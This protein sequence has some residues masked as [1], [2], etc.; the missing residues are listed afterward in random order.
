MQQFR[1]GVAVLARE[2]NVPVVPIY[3]EGLRN[4]MPKGE[5]APRPAAVSVRVGAP[6]WLDHTT[7]VPAATER[8]QQALL[9]LGGVVPSAAQTTDPAIA[10]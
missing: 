3:T 9:S 8:L 10:A 2:T 4:V 7:S 6:V 1:H 5:R